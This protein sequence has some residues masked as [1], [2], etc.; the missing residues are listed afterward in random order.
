MSEDAKTRFVDGLRVTPRHLNHLPTIV[1]DA[2]Q[3]LRRT[4]GTGAVAYGLRLEVAGDDVTLAPGLA[5]SPSALRMR[6]PAAIPVSPPAGAGPFTVV[7]EVVNA[8]DAALRVAGQPTVIT[9]TTTVSVTA[10]PV[11]V[12]PERLA[13]GTITRGGD[14]TLTVSQ[15]PALFLAGGRHGHTG[16]FALD[17][18]GLWR[19]DGVAVGEGTGTA[20][21]QG[22]KG[23]KG[24]RGEKGDPGDKG[25]PGDK[26]DPG[27]KG[28]AGRRGEKGN[29]GDKGDKG[30][31]GANGEKGEKGDKGDKGDPGEKGD[32]GRRGEKGNPGDK[33]DKG[34]KGDPGVKGD[35]GPPGEG[36]RKEIAV[37]ERLSWKP[38]QP[39]NF[40][41]LL[42]VLIGDAGGLRF[43]FTRELDETSPR[44]FVDVLVLV[45]FRPKDSA[46]AVRALAGTATVKGTDVVWKSTD[47]A[48]KLREL[49]SPP[50]GTLSIDL[51]CG[52]LRDAGG[53]PV[54][55][56]P[57]R[58]LG[59]PEPYAPAGIF[60]TWIFKT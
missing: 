36:L 30:D 3:D 39:L 43:T 26:G 12:A 16:A 21:Q 54:S 50:S 22:E 58:M 47:T 25:N 13:I 51:D 4:L 1:E 34:D 8:D 2:I 29:P 49:L 37:V 38:T 20:G 42:T 35:Q 59:L 24:D 44:P 28:D 14:G 19:Y 40:T 56:S 11:A 52:Y 31:P 17:A 5:F 32:A 23:D 18:D 33:G 27:E 10:G 53:A 15:D 6:V 57:L 45:T 60:R 41:E 55:G 7:L 9:A 48:A 46:Q